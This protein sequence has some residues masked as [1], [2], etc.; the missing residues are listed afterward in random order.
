MKKPSGLIMKV[1]CVEML[2]VP[3]TLRKK[4]HM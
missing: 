2:Y 3:H 4:V 1:I